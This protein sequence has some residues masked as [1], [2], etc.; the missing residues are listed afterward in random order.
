M[1]LDAQ[2]T[3]LY[4]DDMPENLDYIKWALERNGYR[5]ITV[6]DGHEAMHEVE[7]SHPDLI[8]LDIELRDPNM[9]GLD[10]CKAIREK[11]IETPIIFLT[12]RAAIEDLE[13]GLQLAGSGSDY[14]R[15][16][17]ELRRYQVE[18]EQI[19][20]YDIALRSGDTRELIA[21]IGATLPLGP[22]QL[23]PDLR[24]DR[25]RV[26]VE[27]LVDDEWLDIHLQPKEYDVLSA[28]VGANGRVVGYWE[29]FSRV[30][31]FEFNDTESDQFEAS[32]QLLQT[33][34]YNLRRKID[35][36][37]GF[38]KTVPTKGYRFERVSSR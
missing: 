27:R 26:V 31:Q 3:I 24:M 12:V 32:R 38:I 33:H 23:T 29:F 19:E 17:D 28:L 6:Q 2:P 7:T 8:I 35:P 9:N 13:R 16:V 20:N 25:R 36:E 34:V 10:V 1:T 18:G 5:C 37:V 14:V 30:F 21:R 4:V 22:E 15:K 11:G